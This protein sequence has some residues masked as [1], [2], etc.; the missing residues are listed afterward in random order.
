MSEVK[1]PEPMRAWTM[2]GG[3]KKVLMVVIGTRADAIAKGDELRRAGNFVFVN[4]P[5]DFT[6]AVKP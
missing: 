1:Q 5:Y 6:I 3:S 4:G 2:Q